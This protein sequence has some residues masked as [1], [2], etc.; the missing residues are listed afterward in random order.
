MQYLIVYVRKVTGSVSIITSPPSIHPSIHYQLQL[1]L[2]SLSLS[3]S[4]LNYRS[5]N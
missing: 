4:I 2:Y 5:T 3:L 1:S